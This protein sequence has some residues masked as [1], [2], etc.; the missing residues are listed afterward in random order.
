MF[1]VNFKTEDLT[2]IN[3][4]KIFKTKDQAETFIEQLGDRFVSLKLI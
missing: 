4:F 1:K 3:F 2:H